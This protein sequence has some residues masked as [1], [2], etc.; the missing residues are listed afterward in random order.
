MKNDSNTAMLN[1]VLYVLVILCVVFAVWSMWRT[2]D[3]R[4][5]QTNL[6]IQMQRAQTT[7]VR[8]QALLN[9]VITYN[10]TAKS[11]ELAQIIQSAQAPQ[12]AAK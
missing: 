6:Q 8:A 12:T 3:L 1:F 11:P 7:T 2:R 9:D 4:Q 5:L 10:A